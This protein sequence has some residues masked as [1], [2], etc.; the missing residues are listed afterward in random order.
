MQVERPQPRLR[1]MQPLTRGLDRVKRRETKEN[2]PSWERNPLFTEADKAG[3]RAY[4][5]QLD[6]LVEQDRLRRATEPL[7]PPIIEN[8]R[9]FTPSEYFIFLIEKGTRLEREALAR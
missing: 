8:G 3:L 4:D 6:Q 9:T 2:T 5:R 1:F 7:P